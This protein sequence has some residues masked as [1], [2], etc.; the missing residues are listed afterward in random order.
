MNTTYIKGT[1]SIEPLKKNKIQA[2]L[3]DKNNKNENNIRQVTD[4]NQADR[5]MQ[6]ISEINSLLAGIT[7]GLKMTVTMAIDIGELLSQQKSEMKHGQFLPWLELNFGKSKR[8][9]E[10]KSERTL[11]K[12]MSYYKYRA[13]TAKCADLTSA[14]NK[15]LEIESKIKEKREAE[16]Q[17][18][19]H[20]YELTNVKPKGW[21]SRHDILYKRMIAKREALK[22]EAE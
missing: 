6:R 5:Q 7:N 2:T 9:C 3:D 20:Q 8:K 11:R 15:V 4:N 12:Y 10:Q 1:R 16:D 14:Y 22:R 18:M 17:E 13:K 21:R 19:L